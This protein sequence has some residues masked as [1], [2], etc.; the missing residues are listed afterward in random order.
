MD[1]QQIKEAI[2]RQIGEDPLFTDKDKERF[3]KN[4]P[5]RRQRFPAAPKIV[6]VLLAFFVLSGPFYT[7]IKTDWFE[8]PSSPTQEEKEPVEETPPAPDPDPEEPT[9]VKVEKLKEVITSI[10][11]KS[12]VKVAIDRFHGVE[13]EFEQSTKTENGN[14]YHLLESYYVFDRH[15]ETGDSSAYIGPMPPTKDDFK[16]GDVEIS[17]KLDWIE[18]ESH[19]L[20]RE[21]T[22]LYLSE[23]GDLIEENYS[24]SAYH[25]KFIKVKNPNEPVV[26]DDLILRSIA[27]SVGKEPDNITK[28]DLLY[29]EELTINASHLSGIYEVDEDIEYF[30]A[31]QSLF[32]LK[33]NQAIIPGELLK[34][35]PYLD[36]ATFIGPTVDDL[37]RVKEGLQTITYLNLINSSFRGTA[38]DILELKSLNIVRVDPAVV[39]NYEDLQ[40][41][42]MDVRW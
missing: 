21:A 3:Y 22:L 39:P 37:S 12:K 19:N 23:E 38:E 35:V 26:M 10:P 5:N 2:N 31:M 11:S 9:H 32:V 8:Q 6:T 36:Q 20:L 7:F 29:L 25:G 15:N 30:K 4:K 40:F 34:E 17:L 33:L 1:H 24:R 14:E 27:R 28:R 42:G 16:R 13:V 41:E 18:S